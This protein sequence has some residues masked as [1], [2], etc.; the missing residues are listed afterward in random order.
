MFTTLTVEPR[1]AQ[2][3][4]LMDSGPSTVN[5]ESRASCKKR[6]WV[7][8]KGGLD[9]DRPSPRGLRCERAPSRGSG[10]G[11]RRNRSATRI[12][13]IRFRLLAPPR[14]SNLFASRK[15][16]PLLVMTVCASSAASRTAT[17]PVRQPRSPSRPSV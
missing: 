13:S 17:R 1:T 5:G 15:L 3:A 2:T 9:A 7:P 11:A 6:P 16:H 14:Q 10:N 4:T 8:R 12:G